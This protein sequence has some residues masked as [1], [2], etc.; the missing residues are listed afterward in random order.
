MGTFK[1]KFF[2]YC[3]ILILILGC[4]D[5]SG[6]SLIKHRYD[7]I[8][9]FLV[10]DE[11]RIVSTEIFVGQMKPNDPESYIV[12]GSQDEFL[13]EQIFKYVSV[14]RANITGY[15][16]AEVI[17]TSPGQIVNL[18]HTGFGIYRDVNN[19][20]RVSQLQEYH[21]EIKRPNGIVY[22]DKVKIPGEVF[23]T[24]ISEGD[25]VIAY[26]KK[27]HPSL[28][29]C[30]ALYPLVWNNPIGAHAFL[31]RSSSNG[32]GVDSLQVIQDVGFEND[33]VIPALFDEEG[34]KDFVNFSYQE[35]V[36]DSTA[37]KAY[38]HFGTTSFS[39]EAGAFYDF[40]SDPKN[41]NQRGGITVNKDRRVIGNFGA[42][43]SFRMKF[44][45]MAKRDSCG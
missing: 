25:T 1:N 37:T 2:E 43:N 34:L 39:D 21:I 41:I 26:P 38:N 24:N 19:E 4:K 14:Y 20:L 3:F 29:F 42:Y 23:V 33:R 16:D 27:D 45:V 31:G 5:D 9:G 30:F 36:L 12:Q 6:G 8:L 22:T 32:Y 18:E 15:D 17:I 7:M 28:E 10:P 40:W 11:D 44:T 35:F 13:S